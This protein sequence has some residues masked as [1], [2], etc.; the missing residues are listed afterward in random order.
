MEEPRFLAD[1]MLGK[2]ARWLIILGYD[3]AYGGSDGRPDSALQEQ[4]QREGRIL[5]TRDTR[6]PEV[7]GL[8]MVLVRPARF[9]DQLRFVLKKLGL[10]P[11]R[12]RL[13]TRCTYCNRPLESVPR[14]EALALVPPLVRELRTEFWRCGKCRRMYWEGTHTARAVEKLERWGIWAAGR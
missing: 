3:A 7:A 4:A 12:Q 11:D 9:E 13:F 6:I 8:R 14:E 1:S 10:A 2:L 5:L